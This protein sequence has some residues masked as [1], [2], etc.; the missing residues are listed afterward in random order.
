M[1]NPN[2]GK[3]E[4]AFK[5]KNCGSLEG[6]DAAGELEVPAAC[7]VCGKGVSFDEETGVRI[8]DPDNWIVLADL[9]ES[10]LEKVSKIHAFDPDL[11]RIVSH[12]PIPST[13]DREPVSI[14][15]SADES[16]GSE[17]QA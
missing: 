2:S 13:A 7:R 8:L 1:P 9:S 10:E 17:D 15:R 5:C 4:Y 11:H 14:D 6:P 16:V 3:I 12:T